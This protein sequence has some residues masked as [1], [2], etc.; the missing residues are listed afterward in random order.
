MP[1]Y[2]FTCAD[3]GATF[4]ELV[5]S[6]DAIA[7]LR[8]GACGGGTLTRLMSTFASPRNHVHTGGC[9][10]ANARELPPCASG[11]GCPGAGMCGLP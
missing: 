5:P 9:C 7:G 11:G 1:I 6:A 10:G 4:E 8:C 3:C 2:E